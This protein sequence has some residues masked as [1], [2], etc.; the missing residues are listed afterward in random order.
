MKEN[1]KRFNAW[2]PPETMQKLEYLTEK[3]GKKKTHL[4]IEA[5]EKYEN[6]KQIDNLPNDLLSLLQ[7]SNA[8]NT[9]ILD[10]LDVIMT[11]LAK[12][13]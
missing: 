6:N 12:R 5:I 1:H 11:L 4:V 10:K 7:K 3:Y 13:Q 9:K 2:F 8:D